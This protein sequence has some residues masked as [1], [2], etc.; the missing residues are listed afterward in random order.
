M[1]ERLLY[2]RPEIHEVLLETSQAV[3]AV[4][5]SGGRSAKQGKRMGWC[6]NVCKMSD[7]KTNS[8]SRSSS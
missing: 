4:C 8:N 2:S 6:R 1:T 3:L 7:T 5:K